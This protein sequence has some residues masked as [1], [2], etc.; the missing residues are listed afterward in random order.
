MAIVLCA[1]EIADWADFSFYVEIER[2]HPRVAANLY[3]TFIRI[4]AARVRICSAVIP[5]SRMNA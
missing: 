2:E 3:L 1:F 4:S 5:L